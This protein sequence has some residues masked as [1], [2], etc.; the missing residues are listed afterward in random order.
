M[1]KLLLLAALAYA[2]AMPLVVPPSSASAGQTR[3]GLERGPE[4]NAVRDHG[5]NKKLLARK[6]GAE[7]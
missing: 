5:E 2:V 3:P 1:L 4:R 6:H 7:V